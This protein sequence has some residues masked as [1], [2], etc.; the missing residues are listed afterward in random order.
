L[1]FNLEGTDTF[2]GVPLAEA[3]GRGGRWSGDALP[4]PMDGLRPGCEKDLL[5]PGVTPFE[6]DKITDFDCGT[7]PADAV[8]SAGEAERVLGGAD[9]FARCKTVP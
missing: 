6:V 4:L 2:R 5:L 1:G 9:V 7:E 3:V 8:D